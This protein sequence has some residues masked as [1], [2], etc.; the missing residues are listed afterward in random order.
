MSPLNSTPL[1]FI[2][3][4]IAITA[5]NRSEVDFKEQ[6]RDL[7]ALEGATETKHVWRLKKENRQ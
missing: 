7:R 6:R 2:H 3:L 5:N 4:L 1:L